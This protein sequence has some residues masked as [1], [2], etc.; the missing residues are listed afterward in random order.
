MRKSKQNF[1]DIPYEPANE[2]SHHHGFADMDDFSYNTPPK[3]KHSTF[4]ESD[5]VKMYL[6]EIGASPL[7]SFKEE[8]EIAKKIYDL[9]TAIPQCETANKGGKTKSIR[10]KK[11]KNIL[12]KTK[13]QK[14]TKKPK[15]TKKAKNIKK[16]K[17][18]KKNI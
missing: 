11:A 15:N 6:S 16:I 3:N 8:T 1:D 17:K 13:K 7:L 14:N 9:K 2:I 18:T 4:E 5:T 10:S 12:N